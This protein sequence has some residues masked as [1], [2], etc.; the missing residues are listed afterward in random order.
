M[1]TDGVRPLDGGV[2]GNCP[3]VTGRAAPKL[4]HERGT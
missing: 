1:T 4:G 2:I 3:K